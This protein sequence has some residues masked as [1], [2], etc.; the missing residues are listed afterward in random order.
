[1]VNVV[2]KQ[3]FFAIEKQDRFFKFFFM[4]SD[5]GRDE[6]LSS[7]PIELFLQTKFLS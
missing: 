3:A 7:L 4:R 2:R 1:V 5:L 6:Q